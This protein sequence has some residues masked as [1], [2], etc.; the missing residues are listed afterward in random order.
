[1]VVFTKTYVDFKYRNVSNMYLHITSKCV[2]QSNKQIWIKI[3][4]TL[5]FELRK[6]TGNLNR[7]NVNIPYNTQHNQH[8]LRFKSD[9]NTNISCQDCQVNIS[10]SAGYGQVGKFA[11][12]GSSQCQQ[13]SP[14]LGP[15]EI[16]IQQQW[17][18]RGPAQNCDPPEENLR[19]NQRETETEIAG[20][21]FGNMEK[22][23][24]QAGQQNFGPHRNK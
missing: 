14:V 3:V 6:K 4:K 10:I 16:V 17:S 19:R 5:G 22:H 13:P 8:K 11:Q 23:G 24:L 2:D 20:V 18:P 7:K 1:M 15:G 12:F 21:W 9:L